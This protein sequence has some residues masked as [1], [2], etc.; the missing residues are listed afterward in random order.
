MRYRRMRQGRALVKKTLGL[1]FRFIPKVRRAVEQGLTVFTFH[2]VT[3]HPSRFAEEYGLAVSIDTFRRQIDWIQSNFN[4]VRPGNVLVGGPIPG[5]A[6]MITFDDGY[7]GS[8]I[9]GL[10]VLEQAGMPAILFLNMQAILEQKPILSAVAC[11][12]DR[13][14]AEFAQFSAAAGLSR[15]FHLTLTPSLLSTFEKQYGTVDYGAVADYQGPLADLDTVKAW[16]GKDGVV[17]GNHL[18]DHWNAAALS[19]AELEEQYKKNEA[20]LLLLKNRVNLFAFTNGQPDTCFS[21]RDV[22]L[23]KRLGAGKLFSAAGGVNR[24]PGSKYLLG[25][26]GLAGSDNDEDYFWFRLGRAVF[27]DRALAY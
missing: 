22:T 17:F 23:L 12:L 26:L 2:E 24:D 15:P 19:L 4:V 14:V 6:A 8:F 9:N 1:A 21:D 5:R 27:D 13:Y 7:M 3:D 16:D 20:A 18:F 11:F 10:R 25:R